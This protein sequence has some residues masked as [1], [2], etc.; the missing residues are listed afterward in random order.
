MPSI[1]AITPVLHDVLQPIQQTV[2][3]AFVNFEEDPAL[4]VH[5]AKD[6]FE[7]EREEKKEEKQGQ[8]TQQGIPTV[9]VVKPKVP[10]DD[11]K[12][13]LTITTAYRNPEPQSP[14]KPS[15]CYFA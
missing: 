2:Q 4:S 15:L 5:I 9:T 6:A 1:D 13:K 8:V 11:L 12:P 10:I 7:R 14:A 3:N